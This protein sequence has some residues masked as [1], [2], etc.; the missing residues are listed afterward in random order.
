M[1]DPF[2]GPVSGDPNR[3]QQVMWN[4]VSNAIKFTP[5]GGK[6]QV[7]LERVNS[8]IE[9]SVADS[10]QG[11]KPEFLPHVF[12]RFRQADAS[13]TR[14]SGG[15]GLGL[16]I[17]K[18]LVELHGGVV[19][20]TSAGEGQGASFI[21]QLPL[22]LIH[23]HPPSADRQH[24][25]ST[26]AG[27]AAQTRA[28]LAGINILVVDDEPD[29]LLLIQR[30]LAECHAIVTTCGSAAQAISILKMVKPDVLISDIGMPEMDGYELIRTIRAAESPG[31][32]RIPAIALT[33]FARSEDRTRALLAGFLVHLAKPVEPA[34]LVATVASVVGR[35]GEHG[36]EVA[37]GKERGVEASTNG[38]PV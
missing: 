25:R 38:K 10:G 3:L 11:I 13:T 32:K 23:T 28:N 17:V 14:K 22:S 20:A 29:S 1:L 18:Q 5:K 30:V 12:E 33:A 6:V 4:L 37:A 31:E 34:E 21:V 15:L 19:R 27:S 2:A 36:M 24:P 7:V 26:T 16:A 9:I 8:H 35:T